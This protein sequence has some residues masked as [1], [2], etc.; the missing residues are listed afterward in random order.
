MARSEAHITCYQRW[1]F[2]QRGL[3]FNSYDALWPRR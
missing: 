1:L 3:S 2:E